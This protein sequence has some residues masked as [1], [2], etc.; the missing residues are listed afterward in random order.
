MT[1]T[2]ASFAGTLPAIQRTQD[3]RYIY[4]GVTYPGVTS[5]LKI[6][7]KSGALMTWAARETAEAMLAMHDAPGLDT[8]IDSIGRDGVVKGATSRSSWKRDEAAHLG[9]QVH[10]WADSYVGQGILPAVSETARAYTEAYADWWQRSGWSVRLSEAAI[11]APADPGVHTGWGGTLD[12]LCRDATGK[13]VLADIKTGKG[14]YRETILQLAAYGMGRFIS[15]LG[16]NA[17]Y[18]M[19]QVDRYCVIHVTRDGV[20]EV[21]L[22]VGPNEWAAWLGCLELAN[23]ADTVKGKL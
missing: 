6:I 16:S 11:V 7:D 19:P 15:P 20:R 1:V 2:D 17:I 22:S 21:E 4:Q 14:V 13:T 23:W 9:S 18:E 3:H 10:A 12:L 5:V 8:M